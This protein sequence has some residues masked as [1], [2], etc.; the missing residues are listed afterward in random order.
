MP[1]ATFEESIGKIC[2]AKIQR[3]LTLSW[4]GHGPCTVR[5]P[6]RP[7][8]TSGGNVSPPSQ[9]RRIQEERTMK[10]KNDFMRTKS[11]VWDSEMQR[12]F[13]F[14]I[15]I[16]G[17]LFYI[18]VYLR[19]ISHNTPI[20]GLVQPQA[21][22]TTGKKIP[23]VKR[24]S[25]GTS[26]RRTYSTQ[27]VRSLF[28]GIAPRYDFLNHLLSSGIDILWRRKAIA[29]L[30]N[31]HPRDILDVATGT[32]D[33]AL[34][35]SRLHPRTI[36]GIDIAPAMLNL[37]RRKVE[38]RGLTGMI[39]FTDAQAEDLPFAQETFDA[40]T[41]AFGV[42]NFS[43]LERG[44]QEMVRVMRPG[45]AMVILEFSRPR[46]PLMRTLYGFYSERILPLVG[47]SLSSKEAYEYLPATIQEFPDGEQFGTVLERAGLEHIRMLPLTFGIVTIYY[48]IKSG[49]NKRRKRH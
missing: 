3:V 32:G 47:A 38:K 41:V 30:Q 40:V 49:T 18:T 16:Q 6:E 8:S 34:E 20:S 17:S 15:G 37:A 35:A 27:Y 36:I 21:V 45:A 14:S 12:S 26:G 25:A 31:L 46:S 4:G 39:S 29:L 1:E 42:R 23:V 5:E 7:G 19:T 11:S 9:D 33:L 28:D 22:V 10:R 48:G 43:S 24:T 13:P 44:L 2:E